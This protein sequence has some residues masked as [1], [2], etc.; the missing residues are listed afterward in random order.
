MKVTISSLLLTCNTCPGA[1]QR[2]AGTNTEFRSCHIEGSLNLGWNCVVWSG[3]GE[4]K[5]L[6]YSLASVHATH[7]RFVLC[8]EVL[9][10]LSVLL[11]PTK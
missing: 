2:K 7:F 4:V 9:K 8:L 11:Q 3:L 1:F 10:H 5:R 6:G